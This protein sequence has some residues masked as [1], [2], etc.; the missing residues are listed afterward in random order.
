M[1]PGKPMRQQ[2]EPR[3]IW[4]QSPSQ[5]LARSEPMGYRGHGRGSRAAQRLEGKTIQKELVNRTDGKANRPAAVL[6]G[7]ILLQR[8][9]R[10]TTSPD[11]R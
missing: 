3:T 9:T 8:G 11:C 7:H 4:A 5:I 2:G 1:E 10:D 6:E